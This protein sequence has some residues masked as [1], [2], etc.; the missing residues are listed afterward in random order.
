MSACE[1]N[2][3]IAVKVLGNS[4]TVL[5]L[6]VLWGVFVQLVPGVMSPDTGASFLA[7]TS[8]SSPRKLCMFIITKK[9]LSGS[10]YPTNIFI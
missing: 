8:V 3:C 9:I 1:D 10:K 2:L 4:H 6:L 5:L 7:E